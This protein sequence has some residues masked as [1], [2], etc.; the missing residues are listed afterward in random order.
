MR[1]TQ[2]DI[3]KALNISLITVQR[4]LN[5]SGYVSRSMREKI[6]SYAKKVN[7]VP[8]KASQVLVRNKIRKISIFSS[9]KPDF[10]WNDVKTGVKIASEQILLFDYQV[11]YYLIPE[12]NSEM[13]LNQLR[14]VI[15]EGV[16]AIA[17]VNQWIYN[18]KAILNLIE[19]HNIPYITLNIDA[20]ESRRLC[21]IGADY[22]SGGRLAAE[23]IGKTLM[24]KKNARVLVINKKAEIQEPSASPDI[25]KQRLEGF[26]STMQENFNNIDYEI[27]FITRGLSENHIE[28]QIE[29]VLSSL[30]NDID[31]IYLIPP[32]NQEFV[33][34]IQKI[35]IGNRMIIVVHD[36]DPLTSKYFEKKLITAVIYQNPILQGYYAVKILEN[37][38]ESNKPPEKDR[39]IIVH[40]LILKENKYLYRNHYLFTGM[41][42]KI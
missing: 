24:F 14:K 29:D 6:L 16:D 35:G 39:I 18:M 21:Y 26:I 37:I 40:S 33:K 9:D 31:A 5:N 41:I 3:A 22:P 13:Y 38:M 19:Q 30:K 25:N 7:Y 36:L 20:P 23:F 12:R 17:L 10:F 27:R 11:Q 34:V 2:K 42:D 28:N 15:D 4:A 1:I 8:H 32:Y